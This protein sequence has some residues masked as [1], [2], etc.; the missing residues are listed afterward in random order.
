MKKAVLDLSVFK[1][2]TEG[3]VADWKIIPG[4]DMWLKIRKFDMTKPI[5]TARTGK[6]SLTFFQ[7][8]EAAKK[9]VVI[10]NKNKDAVNDLKN[11]LKVHTVH[12][13][14]NVDDANFFMN[15][16]KPDLIVMPKN[17]RISRSLMYKDYVKKFFP[18]VNVVTV[19]A[20]AE[21]TTINLKI[22][23][24]EYM[25]SLEATNEF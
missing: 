13:F 14:E 20:G 21:T 2:E 5:L 24:E 3:F 17:L 1:N 4:I 10:V 22:T 23:R 7:T 15:F 11:L 16:Y 18:K 19:N 8:V 9:T 6:H 25:E 12:S